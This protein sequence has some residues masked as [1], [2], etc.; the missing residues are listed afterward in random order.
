M[1]LLKFSEL[2]VIPIKSEIMLHGWFSSLLA[3]LVIEEQIAL[4]IHCQGIVVYLLKFAVLYR[5]EADGF[6]TVLVD[7]EVIVAG[8]LFF[9]SFTTGG[10]IL[11]FLLS[12]PFNSSRHAVLGKNQLRC[13]L[14]RCP[15]SGILYWDVH[16]GLALGQKKLTKTA[17]K[18]IRQQFFLEML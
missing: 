15:T 17:K 9:P 14:L 3:D 8:E 7:S 10:D 4:P 11:Q 18:V 1:Q 5:R 2:N 6:G 12:H 13:D 16:I